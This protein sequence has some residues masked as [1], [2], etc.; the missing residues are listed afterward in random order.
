MAGEK[1][2]SE[3]GEISRRVE[4]S[5]TTFFPSNGERAGYVGGR[6]NTRSESDIYITG[7]G[8]L[9]IIPEGAKSQK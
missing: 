4:T 5:Q 1:I 6:K 2:Q 3:G 7:G 9:I 8:E